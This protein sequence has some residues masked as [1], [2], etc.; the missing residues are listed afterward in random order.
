MN[1]I[2]LG[3]YVIYDGKLCFV[4]NGVSA[5]VWDLCEKS[6]KDDGTRNTY[7][8]HENNFRKAQSLYNLKNG[9]ISLHRW[10]MN[11]WYDIQ[12][13]EMLEKHA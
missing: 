1:H 7:R 2:H 6:F 9:L 12:L 11:Y 10:Y 8:V 13:R 3:D 4:N 5:P